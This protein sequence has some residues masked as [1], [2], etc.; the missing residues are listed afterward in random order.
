MTHIRTVGTKERTQDGFRLSYFQEGDPVF[1]DA[2]GDVLSVTRGGGFP[3]SLSCKQGEET[4]L[5]LRLGDDEGSVPVFTHRCGVHSASDGTGIR[6]DYEVRYPG[7]FQKISM[8]IKV[9]IISEEK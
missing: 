9:K 8:K 7:R 2:C 4:A 3:F 6:L 1:L 5:V